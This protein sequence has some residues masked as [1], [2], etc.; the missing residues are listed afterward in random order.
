MNLLS[1]DIEII[2]YNHNRY[3]C[4]SRRSVHCRSSI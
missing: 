3:C 2:I 1:W 4:I